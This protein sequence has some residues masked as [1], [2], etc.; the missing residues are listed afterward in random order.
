MI[1][2]FQTAWPWLVLPALGLALPLVL[3]PF[4]I[5]LLTEILILAL[6]A[7]AFNLL[8]GG[9]GLL[10]F[11]QAG[12]FAVGAYAAAAVLKGVTASLPL[13]ILAGGAAAA[14]VALAIGVLCVRRDEIYFAMVTLAFGQLI[15]LVLLRWRTV[16]GGS[17]GIAGVPRPRLG[18]AG[19]GVDLAPTTPFYLF[20]LAVVTVCVFLL[21]RLTH[22]PLGLTLRAVRDN[23]RRVDYLG[24]STGRLRLIAFVV[25]GLFSGIA[26]ALFASYQGTVAPDLANWM[27]S[28]EP[29]L[30]TLLGGFS[31]FWGPLAGAALFTLLK[32]TVGSLTEYWPLVIGLTV[33]LLVRFL[34]EGVAGALVRRR[35]PRE[36]LRFRLGEETP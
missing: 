6:L 31:V 33:I 32:D 13:A 23:A 14:V 21:W 22:S 19:F 17:D 11:G 28:A 1:R 36:H 35:A 7:A 16:T 18:I 9:T 3:P 15:H 34:P 10:S 29:V 27:T 4:Y 20:T 25:A 30:M 26:G 12:Y 24:V 5:H 8:F 2:R